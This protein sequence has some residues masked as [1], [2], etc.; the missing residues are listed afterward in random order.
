MSAVT[1][2]Q[3][4]FERRVGDTCRSHRYTSMKLHALLRNTA[5]DSASSNVSVAYMPSRSIGANCPY[6]RYVRT[7]SIEKDPTNNSDMGQLYKQLCKCNLVYKFLQSFRVTR[8]MNGH[9]SETVTFL[10]KLCFWLLSSDPNEMI[11]WNGGPGP[12]RER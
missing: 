6:V 2:M 1:Y 12:H 9:L 10:M 7:T 4:N 8:E 5:H 11:L 3:A